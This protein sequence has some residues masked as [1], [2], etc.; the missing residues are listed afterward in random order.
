MTHEIFNYDSSQFKILDPSENN[1]Y[2]IVVSADEREYDWLDK[3]NKS[4][5]IEKIDKKEIKSKIEKYL[6][7]YGI[8]K[9]TFDISLDYYSLKEKLINLS[10]ISQSPIIAEKSAKKLFH[11]DMVSNVIINQFIDCLQWLRN[12]RNTSIS[13]TDGNVFIWN[14]VLSKFNNPKLNFNSEELLKYNI[15]GIEIELCFHGEFY[16]NYPPVIKIINP[17]LK[18]SLNYRISNSKMAQLDYWTPARSIQ[19]IIERIIIILDKFGEIDISSLENEKNINKNITELEN[20]LI[21]FAS[22]SDSVFENDEIDKDENFIKFKDFDKNQNMND[23]NS[24]NKTYWKKGTG[25]GHHGSTNWNIEEYIMSQKDK[26]E[27]LETIFRN[28]VSILNMN[29]KESDLKQLINLLD[30]SLI[31]PYLKQHFKSSSILEIHKKENLFNLYIMLLEGITNNESIHLFDNELDDKNSLYKIIEEKKIEFEKSLKFDKDNELASKF[32]SIF[33]NKISPN[34]S[35]YIKNKKSSQQDLVKNNGDKCEIKNNTDEKV[36]NEQKFREQYKSKLSELRFDTTSILNTNYRQDYKDLFKTEKNSNWKSC[37]KRLASELTSFIQVNQLPIDYDSSIF[38][39][40]DEDNPMIIR[41]LITGPVDTPYDSGCF[42]FDIYTPAD[43]PNKAPLFWFMNHGGKRF[44]PNLYDSGKVCL[45]VLGTY[46]GPK[47]SQSE[48]WNPEVSTL[49]QVLISIQAQIL[50]DQPYFNEPGFESEFGTVNGKK[51]SDE[52]NY[53]IRLYTMR[54]TVKDLLANTKIYP[55]FE[56]II[57]E[58]FKHKKEHV[59]KTYEKW[60]SESPARLKNEYEK[61]F[62]E[63]RDLF[64]QKIAS[65]G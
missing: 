65:L 43:Y 59:L 5:I 38:V 55:Q 18:D 22:F 50:I 2:Y 14:I 34:F 16:P 7:K 63:I 15:K 36:T 11:K 19:Y 30:K 25:Y 40:A 31:I 13:L 28:I 64:A 32:V 42:I 3:I 17:K 33:N 35:Q 47:P 48:K 53:D 23:Q 6:K 27:K 60:V 4:C 24:S 46:V 56:E 8:K 20:L 51:K 41:A 1:G 12:D 44:N 57:K 39:R 54:S 21:K 62:G 58:H 37:Q 61:V 9:K 26:D 29:H 49:L 52:Y 45:S 10:K